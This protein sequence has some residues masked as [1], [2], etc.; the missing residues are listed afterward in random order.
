MHLF[1]M[2][3]TVSLFFYIAQAIIIAYSIC[4][5]YKSRNYLNILKNT[6]LLSFTLFG[7]ADTLFYITLHN[8]YNFLINYN[9]IKQK[10]ATLCKL[11]EDDMRHIVNDF[12]QIEL[13]K[14][15]VCEYNRLLSSAKKYVD[16]DSIYKYAINFDYE[17]KMMKFVDVVDRQVNEIIE[18]VE[19]LKDMNAI[20]KKL[21]ENDD[22]DMCFNVSSNTKVRKPINENTQS[23]AI[24][25]NHHFD[26]TGIPSIPNI[27]NIPNIPTQEEMNEINNL[28]TSLLASNADIQG[29]RNMKSN[30]LRRRKERKMKK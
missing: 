16:L 23:S 28:F 29:N 30:R 25:N 2:Q 4:S 20:V 6:L 8:I 17:E 1:Y 3:I 10:Y 27:P 22:D 24:L 21:N 26:I 7:I 14:N 15:C 13:V 11:H 5:L 9:T 19:F 18:S 12:Y